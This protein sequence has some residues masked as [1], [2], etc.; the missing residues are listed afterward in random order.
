VNSFDLPE[1]AAYFR[2]RW[3]LPIGAIAVAAAVAAILCL[4]L[5]KQYTATATVVIEPP[6]GDARTAISVSP[7]YLESLKSYEN[8][9]ASDSLFAKACEKFHLLDGTPLES[10]KKRV[11]RVEKPKDTKVLQVSVT[12]PDPKLAQAVVQYL[13]E[14]TVELDLSIARTGDRD[15]VN[16]AE[17]RLNSA[18]KELESA[19]AD[20]VSLA[21][22]GSETVLENQAKSLADVKG[23]EEAERI[24]TDSLLA[25]S[26]ARGDEQSASEARARLKSLDASLAALGKDL[27]ARSVAVAGLRAR[28]EKA[29]DRLHALEATFD[30]TRKR[31]AD[32]AAA[33]KFR[34]GQLRIVDPGIV[35]QR[36]SFPNLPLAIISAVVIAA[37]ACLAWMTLQFGFA[38]RQEQP[39]RA[40]LRVA[41]SGSR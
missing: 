3:K 38:S 15:L 25:E 23:R 41:G 19:R 29:F 36:P 20:V 13:A 12:L 40:G 7:I 18:V 22:A 4:V 31:E 30:L 14:E 16:D 21:A 2:S 6:G 11:L 9:A 39:S 32:V 8:Y 28:R 5:P 35:P 27:E 37:A 33:V 17:Q 10:F 34:T 24:E 26:L 1:F